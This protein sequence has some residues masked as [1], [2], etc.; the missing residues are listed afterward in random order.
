M[1][2]L[3]FTLNELIRIIDIMKTYAIIVAGGSGKRMG[4]NIPK[5]FLLLKNKPVLLHTLERIAS[6]SDN[7]EIVL[8]LPKSHIDYWKSLSRKYDCRVKHT[9]VE[10]G[11]TR[12][13]S[14]QNAL[15]KVKKESI[16]AIHDGVRP[17]ISAGA[18]DRCVLSAKKHGAVIPVLEF[19]DSVRLVE[20]DD[21]KAVDRS[22]YRLVQTPQTFQSEIILKAYQQEYDNRFTDDASVVE[23]N[24][25]TIYL[26]RGNRE[27]IKIT[28][29]LDL[30]LAEVLIDKL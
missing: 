27:N 12:F 6:F 29:Q 3:S 8:A 1:I 16:V 11:E 19:N 30:T 25:R 15:K 28:R 9:I 24:G 2:N 13:H 4:A 21:S 17:L 5:Q 22:K 20:G 26:E 10:G 18:W 14:V 7:L 23:K